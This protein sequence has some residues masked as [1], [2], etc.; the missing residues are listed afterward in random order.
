MELHTCLWNDVDAFNFNASDLKP[1]TDS[2]TSVQLRSHPNAAS[3]LQQAASAEVLL[4]WEFPEQWYARCKNL[5]LILTPAAGNDWVQTDPDGRVEIIHGTFH[6]SL[7]A[8]SLL[9]A[10]LFMNHQMPAMVK[11]FMQRG[12]DRNLQSGSRLLAGQT[13]MIIGFGHIGQVCGR[14]LQGLGAHILGVRQHP[15]PVDYPAEVIATA[16]MQARLP[17]ADH[18]V[19][20]LPGSEDTDQ[21]M[22]IERMRQCKPGAIV[23]NF[24]RGNALQSKDLIACMDHLGGA[25]LDVTDIEPLPADS[26]LWAAPNIMIT[27]HSSCVYTEYKTG[28]I[29]EVISHLQN[30]QPPQHRQQTQGLP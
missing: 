15:A 22:S 11:N 16:E 28:F 5:K 1:V 26:P 19:L 4:T 9:S 13:V 21:F 18:I 3:F 30:Y 24:G 29:K 23:Y 14:L 8:E 20:L 10:V 2:L 12:W 6:G 27:P 7:L 17:D 25:F